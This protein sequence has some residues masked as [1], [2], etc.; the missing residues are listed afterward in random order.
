M[1]GLTFKPIRIVYCWN[2]NKKYLDLLNIILF[3]ATMRGVAH[4]G[5]SLYGTN[6]H[7]YI[8]KASDF[9]TEEGQCT[10]GSNLVADT[11]DW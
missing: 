10:L 6:I 11:Y 9:R 1:N 4:A 2:L 3:S 5:L 8:G 7:K